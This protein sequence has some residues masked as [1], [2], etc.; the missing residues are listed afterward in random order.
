MNEKRK[1]FCYEYVGSGNA[2]LSA[3]NAGYSRKGARSQGLRLLA[4]PEVKNMIKT[5]NEENE[6]SRISNALEMQEKLTSIIR[7]ESLEEVVVVQK[8][9][10]GTS[11]AV[12]V[13]K[14]PSH[15]D[16]IRAIEILGKM[17]GVFT[18]V[19]S[20]NIELPVFMGEDELQD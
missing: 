18:E 9:A 17:R 1:R 8:Q 13:K 6:N 11:K 16:V 7:G 4:I 2:A 12:V 19:C 5:L 14:K 20:L 10:D 3:V 15:R